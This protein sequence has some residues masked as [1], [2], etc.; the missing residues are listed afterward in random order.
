MEQ[1]WESKNKHFYGQIYFWQTC[2]DNSIGK[3]LSFQYIVLVQ[4][5]IYMQKYGV[6]LLPHTVHKN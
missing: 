6:K 1:K 3:G 2:Q 5:D 4:L